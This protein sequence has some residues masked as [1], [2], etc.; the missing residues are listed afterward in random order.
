MRISLTHRAPFQETRTA[1]FGGLA[2]DMEA[3]A[4]S[5]ARRPEAAQLRSQ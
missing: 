3:A 2:I 1:V 4:R 5:S